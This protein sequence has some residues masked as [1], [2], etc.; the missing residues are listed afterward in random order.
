M[1][2]KP[3]RCFRIAQ[4]NH[5]CDLLWL[6][7]VSACHYFAP[8]HPVGNNRLRSSP[9]SRPSTSGRS[10]C[11]QMSSLTMNARTALSS[12]TANATT[13][14]FRA[15]MPFPT[16]WTKTHASLSL[17][18]CNYQTI[19]EKAVRDANWGEI[20]HL[21]RRIEAYSIRYSLII[22]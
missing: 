11:F 4:L 18:K 5:N 2:M 7:K 17:L 13:H 21:N 19:S 10:N 3:C 1:L 6:M 8:F 16:K 22:F 20:K 15:S 12:S 14:F 9:L